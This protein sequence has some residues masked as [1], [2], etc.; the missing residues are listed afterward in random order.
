MKR[1]RKALIIGLLSAGVL[2]T[3]AAHAGAETY[4]F[5]KAHADIT[6][7]V[8]HLGYSSTHGR[9]NDFDGKLMVDADNLANSSVE[10]TIKT[11]SVETSFAKRNTHLQSADFFNVEVHPT[12]IFKSTGI[13]LD[14]ADAGKMMGELTILGQTNPVTLDLKINKIAPHPRSGNMTLGITATGVISR[15][16]WGMD[17]AVPG[18]ADEIELRLDMEAAKPEA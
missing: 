7:R 10:V 13:T 2:I 12:M 1:A 17:F 4:D 16:D 11:A 15:S 5:D 8:S 6:F 9:F 18:I 3:Q 14:S